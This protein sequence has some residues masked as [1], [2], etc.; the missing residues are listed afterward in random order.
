MSFPGSM[1][2]DLKLVLPVTLRILLNSCIF[3][4]SV[5][6]WV[7]SWKPKVILMTMDPQWQR[8]KARPSPPQPG[9]PFQSPLPSW[10]LAVE[11]ILGMVKGWELMC[12]CKH[13]AATDLWTWHAW[14]YQITMATTNMELNSISGR[15]S[16]SQ[17]DNVPGLANCPQRRMWKLGWINFSSL[18]QHL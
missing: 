7:N 15:D 1:G 4:D 5:C 9:V 12:V 10:Q 11:W 16:S 8:E 6:E 18:G 17:T 13:A 14:E 2:R 3:F